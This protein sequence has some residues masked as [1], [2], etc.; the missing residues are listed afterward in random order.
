M[1]KRHSVSAGMALGALWGAALIWIG[2]VHVNIPVFSR[3]LVE[4][5]FLLAPGIIL[6]LMIARIALRRFFDD[7]II[8]GTK[9]ESGSPA[10]IDNRVLKNTLEQVVLAVCLWKPISYILLEDGMGIVMC[11][12]INFAAARLLFWIGYHVSPPLRAFGFAATFYP[13]VMAFIWAVLWW[14]L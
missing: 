14:V 8:D 1:Q 10:D 6:T 3:L 5:F 12:S 13:T 9:P 4:P 11:L 2:T 7:T